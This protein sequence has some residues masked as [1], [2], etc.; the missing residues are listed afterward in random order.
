MVFLGT[1][2][3]E[4]RGQRQVC[5]YIRMAVAEEQKVEY[6]N[7]PQEGWVLVHCGDQWGDVEV[8]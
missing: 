4:V 5:V 1:K 7:Y 2:F 8:T 6:P 3:S